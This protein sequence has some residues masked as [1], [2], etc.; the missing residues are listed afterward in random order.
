VLQKKLTCVWSCCRPEKLQHDRS[1][2][3][4]TARTAARQLELQHDRTGILDFEI[5]R[6]VGPL[7]ACPRGTA[8]NVL[9]IEV[10]FQKPRRLCT[11]P[12][13]PEG[14]RRAVSL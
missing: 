9:E 3:S 5:S 11:C 4:T 13:R 12:Q 14:S 1:K 10:V 8:G 7:P 2:C 6:Q